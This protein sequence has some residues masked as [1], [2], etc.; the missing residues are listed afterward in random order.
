M[1]EEEEGQGEDDSHP[2]LSLPP[3]LPPLRELGDAPMVEMHRA[4]AID[5][6][7][8]L[9]RLQDSV[10]Y[11]MRGSPR[12]KVSRERWLRCGGNGGT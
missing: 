5:E 10:V 2:P 4:M 6:M 9:L 8:A 7:D 3:S 11:E 1:A 12:K